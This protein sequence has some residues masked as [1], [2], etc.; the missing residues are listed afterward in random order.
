MNLRNLRATW[1]R[2]VR[3]FKRFTWG[4]V[5]AVTLP[6]ERR[7]NL[8]LF[9]YDG[10]F[11]AASDKIILTY[12]TIYLLSLGATRQQIGLL[13][14]FSN[15]SA[16]LLLL[17]AALLVERT[18][19]R[20]QVTL[21]SAAGS[22]LAV[23]LMA[24]LPL[25]FNRTNGFIWVVLALALLREIFNNTGF[26]GWMALT[27][28]IVPP[29]GR[30]RYF[31]TR[32]LVMG[33]VGIITAL[34]I[35]EAITRIGEPL[36][37]QLSFILAAIFGVISMSF[38]ARLKD[39]LHSGDA[40][41]KT[42][43]QPGTGLLAILASLKGQTS[44]LRFCAFTAVWNL[45]INIVAP[46]FSVYMVNTLN[47][48][49]AMIGVTTVANSISNM[50]VQR[51]IGTIADRWGNRN[52]AVAAL[53]LIPALPLIWGLWVRQYWQVILIQTIGGLIWGA[54][55]L[56]SFNNLLLQTPENLR[57]RFSAFYQI[58]VTLSLAG[59][60]ALGSYLIDRIDFE[61][62]AIVSAGGRWVAA[63][64]FLVL[65]TDKPASK[66]STEKNHQ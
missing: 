20:Q 6:A 57:A 11:A 8:T 16:A 46:F 65:V 42:I 18:G 4:G 12:I 9:F 22:R 59:G 31:G 23:F 34:V 41:G 52:V 3:R 62:V 49:A 28:D 63:L 5:W 38:F 19:K 1:Q 24:L 10:M 7:Q 36:G 66:E 37:F 51:R 17:P 53:M 55:N 45:A 27:G 56:V 58:I 25:V 47:F 50:I 60:A 26:P 29:E 54:Y 40:E 30:G 64:L 39:P 2:F 13:S 35:G 33:I 48:T 44:F 21:R 14:S 61:G 43:H 32:N 15:L